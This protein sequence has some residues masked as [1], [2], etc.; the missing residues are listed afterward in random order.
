MAA[1]ARKH[2]EPS[3]LRPPA[4]LARGDQLRHFLEALHLDRP[5]GLQHGR[6]YP[7]LPG[8]PAG[9]GLDGRGRPRR[10]PRL[11]DDHRLAGVEGPVEGRGEA[12]RIAHGLRED[13]DDVGARIVHQVLQVLRR[14]R[15]GFVARR[16]DVAVAVAAGVVEEADRDRTALR[17]HADV[18]GQALAVEHVHHE[19]GAPVVEVQRAHAVGPAERDTGLT[20]HGN[21]CPLVLRTLLPGFGEGA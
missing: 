16:D 8:Q 3:P 6:Q 21:E 18:A 17:D 11:E 1:G 13:G 5:M 19:G 2:G 20:A 10:A 15:D 7:R 4:P 12:F 14:R 9:V